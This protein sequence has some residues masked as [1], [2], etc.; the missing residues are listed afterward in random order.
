MIQYAILIAGGELPWQGLY[1]ARKVYG[2]FK[3]SDP[4]YPEEIAE[5]LGRSAEYVKQLIL[6][7]QNGRVDIKT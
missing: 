6:A 7:L 5:E 1:T 4:L 2:N 3:Y